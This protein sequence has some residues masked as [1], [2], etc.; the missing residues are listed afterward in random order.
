MKKKIRTY[1]YKIA[2]L[3]CYIARQIL[4]SFIFYISVCSIISEVIGIS[5]EQAK[6]AIEQELPIFLVIHIHW[7]K[8]P[9]FISL[10]LPF[11]LLIATIN[12][13]TKLSNN[14]ETIAMQSFGISLYRQIIPSLVIACIATVIVFA[15]HELIVPN[16]NY[17][18]AI[19]LEQEWNIDR[20]KLSKYNKKQIVYQEFE[21]NKYRKNLKLLFFAEQFINEQMKEVTIIK[22]EKQKIKQIIV[23]R[24]AKWKEQ[25]QK[26]QLFTG[27]FYMLNNQGRYIQNCDFERLSLK[28]NKNIL[29]YVSHQRDNREMSIVDLYR[30]LAV[31]KYTNNIK[32]VRALKTSIQERYAEALSCII[33]AFLGSVLGVNSK[34]KANHSSLGI[35]LIIIFIYY[36]TRF[37]SS[38]LAASKVISIFWGVWLPNLLGLIIGCLILKRTQ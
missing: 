24:L 29:N 38:T 37:F 33:F 34:K 1:Y 7:L 12:I 4:P 11:S 8:L 2:L 30:R 36:F 20:A 35:A 23:A 9:Y 25:Q 15:F 3:D 26:W 10:A 17:K 32:Q 21:N 31:V 6:L 13:Y 27:S 14:N 16:T 22:Y 19:I 28:L 5:F 18:A